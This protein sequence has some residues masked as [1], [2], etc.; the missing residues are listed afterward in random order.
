MGPNWQ[1]VAAQIARRLTSGKLGRFS[2]SVCS[3]GSVGNPSILSLMLM[4]SE[5]RCFIGRVGGGRFVGWLVVVVAS[6]S[7][8]VRLLVEIAL[9]SAS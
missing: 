9:R 2:E 7:A 3:V 5:R 8:S 4:S 6:T 1:Q